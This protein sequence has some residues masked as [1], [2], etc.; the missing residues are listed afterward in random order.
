MPIGVPRL[1]GRGAWE[2]G[3]PWK[4]LL[5]ATLVV[6]LAVAAAVFAGRLV[7]PK[8]AP[9]TPRPRGARPAATPGAPPAFVAFRDGRTG[10]SIGYPAPWTRLRSTEPSVVLVAAQGDAASLLL[11]VVPLRTEV[12]S[13]GLSRVK[14]LTDRLVRSGRGVKLLAAP[15]P[16]ELG[17]LPGYF[18]LYSF[19]DARRRQRGI[20]SHYFLFAGQTL[21]T[22]VLQ[23]LP[24]QRFE[25]FAPVFDRISSTFRVGA[26]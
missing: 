21:I 19:R 18:Y 7:G 11:R 8:L 24:E 1:P 13:A 15:K 12:T 25:R 4:W 9:S 6:V 2:H 26:P 5:L 14:P 3:L 17:G 10:L 23:A 20:H 16:I 22:L